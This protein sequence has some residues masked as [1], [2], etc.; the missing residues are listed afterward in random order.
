MNAPLQTRWPA[1]EQLG[2][3]GEAGLWL[4]PSPGLPMIVLNFAFPRGVATEPE[5]LTGLSYFLSGMMDEGAGPLDAAAFQAELED[6]AISLRFDAGRDEFRG[7][8]RC[9]ARHRQTAFSLLRLALTEPHFSAD[10]VEHVRGQILAGLRQQAQSPEDRCK[11]LLSRQALAGH[12][13]ARPNKGEIESVARITGEDLRRHLPLIAAREGLRAVLVADMPASEAVVEIERIFGALPLRGAPAA[14][15]AKLAGLGEVFVEEMDVPQTAIGYCGP[16]LMRHDPD[17]VAGTVVNHV[18]GGS[19]FTSRLFMEVREK[20]GLAY[21]VWSSLRPFAAL[22]M[23]MG[24]TATKNER[25]AESLGVIREEMTKLA[26]EGL[27]PE[28]L[29][30]AVKY[31]TG[32]YPLRFDTSSK[33]ARE[34][35]RLALDGFGPEYVAGRNGLFE[36]LTLED[37]NRAAARLY[38]AG[39]LTVAAVGQPTGLV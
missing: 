12:P 7:T 13:Y 33:I 22:G 28:E 4:V 11:K 19:A 17:F 10:A 32:S 24:G 27:T 38:G 1:V 37:V 20:R 15:P 35:L 16:G 6:H 9:L 34:Y 36:A 30:E 31:L 26:T 21:S 3:G 18:L 23:H 29:S 2:I 5:Q 8:L 14:P 39:K 25:A